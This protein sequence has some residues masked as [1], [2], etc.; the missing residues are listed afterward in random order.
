M[1]PAYPI[2]EE[3]YLL[4]QCSLQLLVNKKRVELNAFVVMSNHI[5]YDPV[6]QRADRGFRGLEMLID[7]KVEHPHWR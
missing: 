5:H 7:L 1:N 3:Q 2:H 6:G 4:S